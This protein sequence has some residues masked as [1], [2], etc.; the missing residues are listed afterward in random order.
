MLTSSGPFTVQGKRW[1]PTVC[2][3][4]PTILIIMESE[5]RYW[6]IGL[7]WLWWEW[8]VEWERKEEEV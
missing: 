3:V 2:Y 5:P 4:L 1:I 8:N 7:H 6:K